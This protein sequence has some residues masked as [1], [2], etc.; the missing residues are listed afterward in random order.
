MS[1]ISQSIK[2]TRGAGLLAVV[3]VALA[4]A[5]CG[6]SSSSD[7]TTKGEGIRAGAGDRTQKAIDNGTAAGKAAGSP[8]A[9]PAKTVGIINFLGGIESSD[10]LKTTQTLVNTM[11]G[12]KSLQCD[13]KGTP[14]QFVACGNELL[15]R[16]VDAIVE[17][18][19]DPGQIQGVLTKAKAAKVPV[20]QVGGGSVPLGDLTGTYGPDEA[21]SGQVLTD[22][23][24]AKLKDTPGAK[25]AI[26]D[27]P[28]AWAS[29][30]T[31]T[32][33]KYVKDNPGKIDVVADYETDGAT[34]VPFTKKSTADILTKNPDLKAYWYTFDTTGQVGGQVITSTYPGKEFP[35]KPWVSTF[36]AD[37][38]TLALM[39]KGDI[40][41]T[42]EANYDAANWIAGDQLAGYW[43]RQT[44]VAAANPIYPGGID[45]FSYQLITKDNL[46]TKGEYVPPIVDVPAYFT[47]KW[48][49]QFT[50]AK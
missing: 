42:S 49:A 14:A 4:A 37:L 6:S 18:A 32:F 15:N 20:I 39:A 29:T 25:V 33:R 7:T 36:H 50:N 44:A 13:G 38:G 8:I 48:K 2:L 26:Q 28:A 5:G 43:T 40:D 3:V 46:P 27:F 31:D 9:V 24:V 12:W 16:G 23:L 19:I 22:G 30:R 10:R 1:R 45:M 41:M 34:L 21:K 47:A 17:I 11:L 35:N